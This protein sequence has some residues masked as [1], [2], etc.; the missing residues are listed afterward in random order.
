LA[1]KRPEVKDQVLPRSEQLWE[2]FEDRKGTWIE[3]AEYEQK[4]LS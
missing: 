1:N 2:L 4:Q 3:K